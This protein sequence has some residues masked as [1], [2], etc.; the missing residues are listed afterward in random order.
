MQ[1]IGFNFAAFHL[2]WLVTRLHVHLHRSEIFSSKKKKIYLSLLSFSHSSY[3]HLFSLPSYC[4]SLSFLFFLSLSSYTHHLSAFSLSIFLSPDFLSLS[5][6]ILTFSLCLL[7]PPLSLSWLFLSLSLYLLFLFAFSLS[8][9]FSLPFQSLLLTLSFSPLSSYF[10][11]LPAI[12]LPIPFLPLFSL[13]VSIS[14]LISLS[15]SLVII[16]SL[17]IT[18]Q[19]KILLHK[20][21]YITTLFS[22]MIVFYGKFSMCLQLC[23]QIF[24]VNLNYTVMIVVCAVPQTKFGKALV[25]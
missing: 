12:F 11:S 10:L 19:H 20:Y 16:M 3:P 17:R 6:P 18:T 23:K 21:M 25:F 14:L 5:L 22:T 13:C 15:R 4:P 9:S 1:T 2:Q 7:T 24:C 8:I